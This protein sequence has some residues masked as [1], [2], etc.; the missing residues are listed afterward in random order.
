MNRILEI[1]RRAVRL[2]LVLVVRATAPVTIA[3]VFSIRSV[4][5]IVLPVSD[6]AVARCSTRIVK[7][8]FLDKFIFLCICSNSKSMSSS[9]ISDNVRP[10]SSSSRF[11]SPSPSRRCCYYYRPHRVSPSLRCMVKEFVTQRRLNL[12]LPSELCAAL[13]VYLS[14]FFLSLLF[15]P[16]EI[17][18]LL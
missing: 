7:F 8:F 10:P 1:S 9:V 17:N 18:H 6:R 3:P 13:N 14:L 5:L 2:V 12:R 4:F 15:L 11:L 16:S